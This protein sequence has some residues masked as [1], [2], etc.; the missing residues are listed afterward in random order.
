MLVDGNDN[1]RII[2][3]LTGLRG[4]AASWVVVYHLHEYDR[5]GGSFGAFVHRGYL[6]VDVFFV[7]SGFVM[8]L[9]YAHF[10]AAGF[11]WKRYASYLLRRA[12]RIYPLYLVLT[13]SV[14]ASFVRNHP[15]VLGSTS[16]EKNCLFNVALIDFWGFGYA[17]DEATWSISTEFAAYVLFPILAIF[18]LFGRSRVAL[19]CGLVC[20]SIVCALPFISSPADLP[21]VKQ[22]A[23]DIAWPFGIW[24][25]IR[26]VTEFA[27]GLLTFRVWSQKTTRELFERP[28]VS[29]CIATSFCLL[30][31][32]R[33]ADVLIVLLIP[34]LLVTLTDGRNLVARTFAT[35]PLLILG[36]L[37][38]AIYLLHDPLLPLKAV[39]SEQISG[40]IGL[41]ASGIIS[42]LAFF[43]AL[44]A[45][46]ALCFRTIE[47]PGR[48]IIRRLENR[49]LPTEDRQLAILKA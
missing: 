7:L 22:G 5:I 44:L 33:G 3:A 43:A 15:Q 36:E 31:L 42:E 29:W 26:C 27:L 37:S 21:Y 30:L 32:W 6:A 34:S 38:Y 8:S 17:L 11:T 35:K 1:R 23:L 2:P 47:Q 19:M 46:S 18:S 12:A 39:L 49:L 20:I 41:F 24:P 45:L 40:Y 16:F 10:F 14:A 9:S 4:V 13:V 28:W 25:L 48:A